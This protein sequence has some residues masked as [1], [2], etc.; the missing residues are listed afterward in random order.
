MTNNLINNLNKTIKA[1]NKLDFIKKLLVL[2][3]ILVFS[4]IILNNFNNLSDQHIFENFEDSSETGSNKNNFIIKTDNKI[5]DT[6]Y[7]KYY[8]S[9]HLNKKRNDFE[10]N[11]IVNIGKKN[12]Y[13]KILDIGCGTGYHVNALQKKKYSVLGLD[14]SE[15][16]VIKAKEKYP[17]CEFLQGDILNNSLF[18]YNTFTHILCLGQTIYYIK[19][20][21]KFFENCYSLLAEG[22]YLIVHLVNRNLFR[23]YI[24]PDDSTVVYDPEKYQEKKVTQTIVKFDKNNEYISN[25]VELNST[26]DSLPYSVYKEKFQNF[27]TNNIRK[28]EINLYMPELTKILSIAKS[29]GFK[30]HKKIAMNYV[31]YNNQYLYV[32]KK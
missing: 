15:A 8:D 11:K 21:N 12:K 30:F 31:N 9:L 18:D 17:N 13:T 20:K 28:N 19:N 23:P 2:F 5:F 1:F 14:Q 25:Y 22:G 4:F 7:A 26:N 16:M 24:S 27:S 3:L 29:K 32:F 6:F 10:I